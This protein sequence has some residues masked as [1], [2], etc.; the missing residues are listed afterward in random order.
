MN[1]AIK[2]PMQCGVWLKTAAQV[3][4]N[5]PVCCDDFAMTGHLWQTAPYKNVYF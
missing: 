4:P 5:V 1:T 3:V 2:G